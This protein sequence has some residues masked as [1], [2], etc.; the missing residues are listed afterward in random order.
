VRNKLSYYSVILLVGLGIVS[1]LVLTMNPF[2]G[3]P[4]SASPP[5]HNVSATTSNA[6]GIPGASGLPTSNSPSA[7]PPAGGGFDDGSQPGAA[8]WG[9]H[10]HHSDDSPGT[11]FGGGNST[12]TTSTASIYSQDE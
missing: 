11:V 12:V 4:A 10:H 5:T 9:G 3:A 8:A 1:A 2:N 7:A 6:S